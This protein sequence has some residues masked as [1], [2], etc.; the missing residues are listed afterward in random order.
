MTT[1]KV[2]FG[3]A[4]FLFLLFEPWTWSNSLGGQE[5]QIPDSA[6]PKQIG[7]PKLQSGFYRATVFD[8]RTGRVMGTNF[9]RI[10][11][12]NLG[13]TVY[14]SGSDGPLYLRNSLDFQKIPVPAESDSGI[15]YTY[16]PLRPVGGSKFGVDLPLNGSTA[17]LVFVPAYGFECQNHP[18]KNHKY[19]HF[20][21]KRGDMPKLTKLYGCWPW[22]EIMP[23]TI[24][25]GSSSQQP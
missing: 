18:D 6:I 21:T 25:V 13:Q 10:S 9:V 14:W 8:P 11:D 19:K 7:Q 23:G 4:S 12:S 1:L 16:A 20:T 17:Y 5:K 22:K 24:S 2:E 3:L 15:S